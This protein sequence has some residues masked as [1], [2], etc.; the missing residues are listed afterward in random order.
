MRK[1]FTQFL[2]VAILFGG[3]TAV[4]W[5]FYDF[6]EKQIYSVFQQDIDKRSYALEHELIKTRATLRHWKSFYE[7]AGDIQPEEFSLIAL[8]V[9]DIYPSLSLI[10]W[11]PLV[12]SHQRLQ[13]KQQMQEYWPGFEI[14]E[15]NPH[16]GIDPSK[17]DDT[18]LKQAVEEIDYVSMFSPAGQRQIYF[19]IIV[20]EPKESVGFIIGLDMTSVNR[21]MMDSQVMN[22]LTSGG[23]VGLSAMPSPFSPKHEPIFIALVPVRPASSDIQ[24]VQGKIK[25]F[26]S[27]SFVVED[28]LEVSSLSDLPSDINFMLMDETGGEGLRKLYSTGDFD[29]SASDV[30]RRPITSAFGRKWVVIASPKENYINSRRSA[31]PL[32]IFIS[33]ATCAFFLLHYINLLR[34]RAKVVEVLVNKKSGQLQTANKE[35][36]NVNVKLKELSRIDALT[37]VANR[38]YFNQRLE[39]E[40]RRSMRENTTLTLLLI[41]VDYFKP[42]NDHYGHI[43][44][45]ETLLAVATELKTMFTRSGDL[46]ARYGGEEFAVILSNAG[47]DPMHVAEKCLKAIAK[48]NIPHLKSTV[49]GHITISVGLSSVIPSA[50]IHCEELL[51]CADQGLYIAKEHGRNRAIY[52]VFHTSKKDSDGNIR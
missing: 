9:L 18:I 23:V 48:L 10:S 3:S 30:R 25:G 11:A 33:A 32:V 51:G 37:Q 36:K 15:L 39:R 42:Y 13:F 22:S 2:L 26:I 17:V 50:E 47:S 5:Y 12:L 4:S 46:V 38:R 20:A 44:G 21:L 52:Q 24:S 8:D 40:W 7:A 1:Y 14:R 27:A 16:Y 19:P 28:L 6:D 29:L 49:T 41:D 34:S 35:L 45:D 31:L 43:K